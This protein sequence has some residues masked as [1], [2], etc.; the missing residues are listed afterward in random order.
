MKPLVIL[1]L[2]AALAAGCG[3][4]SAGTVPPDAATSSRSVDPAPSPPPTGGATW[5]TPVP[6]DGPS[7]P[8]NPV[9]VHAGVRGTR[10]FAVVRWWGG[11]APCYVLRPVTVVRHGPVIRVEVREGSDAGDHTA[12]IE[13]ALLKATRVDLGALPP[14]HYVVI[15][16]HVRSRL[17]VSG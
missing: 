3:A 2:L 10:A 13:L 16:E 11:V 12:C 7:H 1:V 15:A 5:L 14:G 17:V 4:A 8:V 6:G 9:A